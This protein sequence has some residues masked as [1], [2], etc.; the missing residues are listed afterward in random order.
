[1]SSDRWLE[2]QDVYAFLFPFIIKVFWHISMYFTGQWVLL[3][4]YYT[5]THTHILSLFPLKANH[6]SLAR[7]RSE[8]MSED[9]DRK[10]HK[11]KFC[12]SRKLSKQILHNWRCSRYCHVIWNSIH[13]PLWKKQQCG[14]SVHWGCIH[15]EWERYVPANLALLTWHKA[16]WSYAVSLPQRTL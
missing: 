11:F 6:S 15:L 13:V 1:M 12:Y 14:T 8:Q 9:G 4:V 2:S 10:V 5:L 16:K 7:R 3:C